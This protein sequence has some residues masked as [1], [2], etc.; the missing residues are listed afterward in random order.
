MA[1][2]PRT[3]IVHL[4][5]LASMTGPLAFGALLSSHER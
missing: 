3:T 5:I 4:V 1:A 2:T